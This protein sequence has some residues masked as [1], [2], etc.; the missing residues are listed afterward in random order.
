[1]KK[2]LLLT[3]ALFVCS[4][5]VRAQAT[6][7]V[8]TDTAH[9]FF[10][11]YYFKT[12]KNLVNFPYYKVAFATTNLVQ[13]VGSKFENSDS[14]DVFGLE[15]FAARDLDATNLVIPMRL[16]LCTLQ[17]NIP[18]LPALD[19]VQVMIAG[20]T[21]LKRF[22]A[23]F[24]N[25]R[26]H[27]LAK[28]FAVLMRN[29]STDAGDTINV[30]RT[31]GKTHTNTAAQPVDR[32]S[33]GFGYV[34]FNYQFNSATDFDKAQ[35]F[36]V[37]TDY[38]FCLAPRVTYTLIADHVTAENATKPVCIR[39]E[40]TFTNLSS[41]RFLQRQWNL[42]EFAR[43]WSQNPP[44]EPSTLTLDYGAGP[45]NVFPSDSSVGW[46]FAPEDNLQD[47]PHPRFFLPWNTTDNQVVFWTDSALRTKDGQNDSTK[48][49]MT[50][51]FRT[52]Y[53]TM[54]IYGRGTYL[55]YNDTFQICTNYCGQPLS[56]SETNS[57]FPFLKVYPNPS[58]GLTMV[59]G[60]EGG[61][62]VQVY[63]VLGQLV[64]SVSTREEKIELDLSRQ[65]QGTYLVRVSNGLQSRTLRF[66]RE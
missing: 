32:H 60:L 56:V 11:K 54:A 61:T 48:C 46:Y 12:A 50:N 65:P 3:F 45:V 31:A 5:A 30:A 10:N 26:V 15:A 25:G 17:N 33:D 27:R 14:I 19:S 1:M 63:D 58:S 23:D 59:S 16:Y 55:L 13:H 7:T 8:V 41:K 53:K 43:K 62:L 47:N 9:Y 39:E 29:A 64:Q 35:G 38:E 40:M 66:I 36:G 51:E 21:L 52:R 6:P 4:S 20:D 22:G 37:G 18:V 57:L 34:R 24:P 2:L 49:F 44:F 28:D 42:V